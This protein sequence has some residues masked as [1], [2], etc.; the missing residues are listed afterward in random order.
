MHLFDCPNEILLDIF[1][2]RSL[3][4]ADL[5]RLTRSCK[6]VHD[7][8]SYLLY[9]RGALERDDYGCT[10]LHRAATLGLKTA[11]Q[12]LLSRC[13]HAEIPGKTPR[14]PILCAIE[15]GHVEVVDVLLRDH[16][17]DLEGISYPVTD[18]INYAVHAAE[19]AVL[20]RLLQDPR[21]VEHV[22]HPTIWISEF[23]ISYAVRRGEPVIVK[24]LLDHGVDVNPRRGGLPIE[25]PLYSAIVAQ[26]SPGAD[27]EAILK[28]LLDAGADIEARTRSGLTPLMVAAIYG[29]ATVVRMLLER[30]AGLEVTCPTKQWNALHLAAYR[31]HEMATPGE[32]VE[33]LRLLINAGIPID[34][35]TPGGETALCLATQAL[36]KPSIIALL[37]AGANIHRNPLV[38][39][40]MA[41][42]RRRE[43]L[44]PWPRCFEIVK[45]LMNYGADI[46]AYDEGG[47]TLLHW[48]VSEGIPEIVEALVKEGAD[49]EVAEEFGS[50]RT[51]VQKAEHFLEMAG[52]GP[53]FAREEDYVRKL[54]EIVGLLGGN[55]GSEGVEVVEERPVFQAFYYF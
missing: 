12:E 28:I 50:G 13:P 17:D 30:G 20:K 37:D 5:A 49:P 18:L 15:N 21:F 24:M 33:T 31:N 54:R 52:R 43:L 14:S 23:P 32:D 44:H 10:G 40:A 8:F 26:T 29:K 11:V 55:V 27:A 53:W 42:V 7:N 1:E 35:P 47:R 34:Q 48:A 6:R 41:T 25:S 51:A 46:D 3:S 36:H 9:D 19:P 45:V 4:I 2:D 16:K 22:N 39:Q 38:H